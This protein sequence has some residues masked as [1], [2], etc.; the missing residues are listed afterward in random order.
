MTTPQSP[1]EAPVHE[2]GVDTV[3]PRYHEVL[4]EAGWLGRRIENGAML[5]AFGIVAAAI[6]LLMEVFLRYV[7]NAPTIWA[8]ETSTFLCA[9]AFLYGGLFCVARD[10]HIRVVMLY[11]ALPD[12]GRRIMDMV[13]SVASTLACAIFAYAAWMVVTRAVWSPMGA[14]RLERSGSAWNPP[15]PAFLKVFL[16]VMLLVMCAQFAWI[17][18]GQIQRFRRKDS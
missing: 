6:M 14:I 11:E 16:F 18:I 7:L 8:H 2:A 5:F 17:L 10:K 13:I 4:P 12:K 3:A 15:L 9:L 1:H